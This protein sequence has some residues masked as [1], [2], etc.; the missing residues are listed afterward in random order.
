MDNN[1]EKIAQDGV[2]NGYT[3]TTFPAVVDRV[4]KA[5]SEGDTNTS[6]D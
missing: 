4:A 1:E 3:K 2:H 5:S 6:G